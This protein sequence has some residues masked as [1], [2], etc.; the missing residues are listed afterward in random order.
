MYPDAVEYRQQLEVV[1][2]M[3]TWKYHAH[4]QPAPVGGQV[5]LSA[6]SSAGTPESFAIHDEVLHRR[7][8]APY[9]RVPAAC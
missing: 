6:Q 1:S 7:S 2:S 9:V 4:R 5:K 3:P 8:T